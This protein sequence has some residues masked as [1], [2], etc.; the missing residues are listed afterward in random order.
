MKKVLLI[1]LCVLS[2]VFVACGGGGSSSEPVSLSVVTPATESSFRAGE[3]IDFVLE[4][5]SFNL[6]AP[7]NLRNQNINR[8]HPGEIEVSDDIVE[9][10]LVDDGQEGSQDSSSHD[11]SDDSHSD[12]VEVNPNAREGHYHVY[13][14]AASGD[15]PHLTSWQ[16]NDSFDLSGDIATG[17]HSL[18]FELRDNSHA[19]VG[20]ETIYFFQVVE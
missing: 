2:S 16:Y 14:D 7:F 4:A 13:L 6:A 5:T 10:D 8:H 20:I 17:M 12:D 3:S 18:R 19:P 11:D 9:I 15:D 1:A